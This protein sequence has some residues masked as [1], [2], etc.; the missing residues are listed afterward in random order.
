MTWLIL[1]FLFVK[2]SKRVDVHRDLARVALSTSKDSQRP[3]PASRSVSLHDRRLLSS[4]PSVPPAARPVRQGRGEL[5]GGGSL[6]RPAHRPVYG[7]NGLAEDVDSKSRQL[8]RLEQPGHRVR[9]IHR[10]LPAASRR[11]DF[12]QQF[13]D[14]LQNGV[15]HERL[16]LNSVAVVLSRDHREDRVPVLHEKLLHGVLLH[17]CETIRFNLR[18]QVEHCLLAVDVVHL[19][20]LARVGETFRRASTA[21]TAFATGLWSHKWNGACLRTRER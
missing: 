19:A 4:P 10:R 8:L 14:G 18:N 16:K 15:S 7:S 17:R 2:G 20:M 11:V 13:G 6:A 5:E 9:E 1:L 21:S 12:I 3:G